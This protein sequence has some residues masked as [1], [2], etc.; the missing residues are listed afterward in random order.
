[1]TRSI[2]LSVCAPACGVLC[3][4]VLVGQP[5]LAGEPSRA[6]LDTLFY[7]PAQRQE[8]KRARQPNTEAQPSTTV[9]LS[10]VVRRNDRRGTVWVNNKALPEGDAN[11]PRILG[12]DAV[13]EGQRL[14]VGESL[15]TLS[16][17]RVDLVAPGAVTVQSQP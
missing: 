13:V 2:F 9:R 16:G 15:D 5:A 10:G 11:T 7:T 3:A 4:A 8:I 1:M 6:V 14:R 17:T 12:V